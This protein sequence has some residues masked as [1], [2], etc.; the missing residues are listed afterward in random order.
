MGPLGP[1]GGAK[2][3]PRTARSAVRGRGRREAPSVAAAIAAVA[4]VAVAV[5]VVVVAAAVA[6]ILLYKWLPG[7]SNTVRGNIV[8]AAAKHGL[9]MSGRRQ[10]LAGL[11]NDPKMIP[12]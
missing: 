11:R 8:D 1:H 6:K 12:K 2:R 3:R 7:R 10:Q 4:A 9:D 5:A